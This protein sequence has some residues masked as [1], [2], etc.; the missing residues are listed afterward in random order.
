MPIRT[1]AAPYIQ[2]LCLSCT[3][4]PAR[5]S[6]M[7]FFTSSFRY[8]AAAG[9]NRAAKRPWRTRFWRRAPVSGLLALL[10]ALLCGLAA[11]IVLLTSDGFPLDGWRIQ[12][13]NVQPTVLLSVL[14]T[15]T[16]A[17]F[18]YAFTEGVR[19]SWWTRTLDGTANRDSH[20]DGTTCRVLLPSFGR[21]RT[22]YL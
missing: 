6:I 18:R 5:S 16:N 3:S 15:I 14:A 2:K 21:E 19:M 7:P 8:H 13:Y 9:S 22:F 1:A 20:H 12:G 4:I 10:I 11:I 17:L